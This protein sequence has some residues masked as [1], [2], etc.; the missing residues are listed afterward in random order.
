MTNLAA[1]ISL[2]S[3]LLW[4]LLTACAATYCGWR[5]LDRRPE[6]DPIATTLPDR[7]FGLSAMLLGIFV[8]KEPATALRLLFLITLIASVIGLKVVSH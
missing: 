7:V 4:A 2:V 5:V 8:F 3:Q 6:K 1:M